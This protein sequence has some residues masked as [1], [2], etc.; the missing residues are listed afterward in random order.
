MTPHEKNV[1]ALVAECVTLADD[2]LREA[3]ILISHEPPGLRGT[4]FLSQQC[5]EKYLKAFLAT[6]D[7]EPPWTHSI[8]KLLDLIEPIDAA[9]ANS[10]RE[11]DALSPYGVTIRYHGDF[12]DMSPELAKEAFDLASKV[13]DAVREALG[14]FVGG[15]ERE[16]T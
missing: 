2:D 5:A 12:P 13:R 15:G 14:E 3:D 8:E 10:L 9:L 6:N 7:V 1:R 4:A 16:T 11:A